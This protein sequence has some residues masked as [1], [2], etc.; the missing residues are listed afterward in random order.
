MFSTK[1]P[2][3][4]LVPSQHSA[5]SS[6]N[7]LA[8]HI[9]IFHEILAT[10]PG[11]YPSKRFCSPPCCLLEKMEI[12]GNQTFHLQS[13]LQTEEL[14]EISRNTTV[15]RPGKRTKITMENHHVQW[16]NPRT[17]SPF[18]SSQTVSLYQAG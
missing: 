1:H 18:S 12:G 4:L 3:V 11:F 14:A 13:N 2:M 17:K 7:I 16:V 10:C 6:P 8:Q 5:K 15:T 9:T